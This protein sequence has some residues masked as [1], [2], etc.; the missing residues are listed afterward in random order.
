[1]THKRTEDALG[2]LRRTLAN[3]LVVGDIVTMVAIRRA[4]PDVSGP[5]LV[6]DLVE[7]GVNIIHLELSILLVTEH[8]V[9]VTLP[10][11]LTFQSG[12]RD[13]EDRFLIAAAHWFSPLYLVYSIIITK[14]NN[15]VN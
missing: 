6:G 11:L 7:C 1:M 15:S 8:T 3:T 5:R 13:R 12:T 9:V 2:P 10:L 14:A 4:R